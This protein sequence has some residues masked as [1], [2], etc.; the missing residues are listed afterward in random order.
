MRAERAKK[1]RDEVK[2]LYVMGYVKKR[3]KGPN[4]LSCLKKKRKYVEEE[5]PTEKKKR[6]RSG[7]RK[8]VVEAF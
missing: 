7:K 1:R 5:P 8:K 4:P 2:D 6:K 3:A